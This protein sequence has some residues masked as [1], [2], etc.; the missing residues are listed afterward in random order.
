MLSLITDLFGPIFAKELVEMARRWRY[1]QNRVLFGGLVLIV[2]LIV[3]QNWGFRIAMTGGLTT[4]S[5]AKMAEVFFLSYL[6]VQYLTVFLFVPFFLTGVISGEREQK[7]LDLLFTTQLSNREIIFGKLGSRVVSMLMLIVSGIPIV[8]LTMLFGGVNVQVFFYGMISTL[9]LVLYVSA[10]AIYF[11]TTTKTTLGA[12]VRTYWWLLCWLIIVPMILALGVELIQAYLRST[13]AMS[14]ESYRWWQMIWFVVVGLMNPVA[15]F[16]VAMSDTLAMQLQTELGSWYFYY[17]L[18]F[19]LLWSLL[20]IFLAIRNVRI[21]PGPR[22][23]ARGLRKII[24]F[25]GS[26]L[27]LK[28]ITS[29]LL[30]LLPKSQ[31]DRWLWMPINNPLWERSR[32]AWVYDREQHLQRAQLGGWILVIFVLGLLLWLEDN[33]FKHRESVM[34]FMS[35]IWLGLAIIASLVGGVSIINDRRKG[36]FEFVLVT[37]MEPWEVIQGAFL[38]SW[39]HIKKTYLLIIVM[40]LFFL[41]MGTASIIGTVISVVIGTL[42]IMLAVL[43]GIACSLAAR[44]IAGALLAS[45]TF[46]IIV[47]I[48]TPMLS[49]MFRQ[50]GIAILWVVCLILLPLSWLFFRWK[51]NAFTVTF[52]LTVFH[53]SLAL[54]FTCWVVGHDD[55]ELPLMGI[56]PAVHIMMPLV[57]FQYSPQERYGI[58]WST[59]QVIYATMIMLN[60][61]WMFWWVCRHYEVLSGRKE[62]VRKKPKTIMVAKPATTT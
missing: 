31:T 11:S 42:L 20:L 33:F 52:L 53:L 32:R 60:L 26:I 10:T 47:V 58:I 40:M 34:I 41:A 62:A 49:S 28:P 48:V 29:R 13:T 59:L 21:D 16:A 57:E 44:G 25:I 61:I 12:L 39:R 23:F 18:I 7:T 51:K 19:P 46:P 6:W 22:K 55:R 50:D 24:T 17:L 35:F 14:M 15:S 37:P 56:H 36:F 54:L 45:F 30:K 3:Y 9:L 38:A 1:Y 2:L 27:I 4:A 5:L 8:A 43:H